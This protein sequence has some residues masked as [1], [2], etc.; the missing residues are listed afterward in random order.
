MLRNDVRAAVSLS[1]KYAFINPDNDQ[2]SQLES[3][4]TKR[5]EDGQGECFLELGVGVCYLS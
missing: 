2:F 4:L 1:D 3:L 5:L